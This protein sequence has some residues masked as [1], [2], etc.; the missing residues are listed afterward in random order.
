MKRKQVQQPK[1]KCE[2]IQSVNESIIHSKKEKIKKKGL[3]HVHPLGYAILQP[4]LQ[5]RKFPLNL[6]TKK[7]KNV[8][9]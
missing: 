1:C 6:T 9:L 8:I 7:N 2:S 4:P 3:F 5:V